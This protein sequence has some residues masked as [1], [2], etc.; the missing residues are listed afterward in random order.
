[1][2]PSGL[3]RGGREEIFLGGDCVERDLILSAK[4]LVAWFSFFWLLRERRSS[5]LDVRMTE[6]LISVGC[7]SAHS[8]SPPAS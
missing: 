5:P 6:W 7:C 4:T 2:D 1:M 8:A 3:L